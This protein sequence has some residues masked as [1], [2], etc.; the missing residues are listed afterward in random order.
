VQLTYQKGKSAPPGGDA[1]SFGASLGTIPDYG[2]PPGG[3]PGVLL[4]GVRPGGGADKAGIKRGDVIVKIGSH[5]IRSVEDLMYA[6][7]SFKPGQSTAITVVREQKPVE[8]E[9]TF[10]DPPRRH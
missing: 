9:A 2:G 8:L 6:L 3:K 5:D 7:Q 10:Q 4:A 1:R